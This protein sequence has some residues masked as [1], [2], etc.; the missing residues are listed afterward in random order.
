MARCH[1]PPHASRLRGSLQPHPGHFGAELPT[2][3]AARSSTAGASATGGR[4]ALPWCA[5][6]D[7]AT[8]AGPLP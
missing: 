8:G 4:W 3:I 1:W 7:A 6:K 5:R 2:A